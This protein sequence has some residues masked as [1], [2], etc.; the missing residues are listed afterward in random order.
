MF[1]LFLD[2]VEIP[3][4]FR[5]HA[6]CHYF[7]TT[8]T[9]RRQY[10]PI[11]I[12]YCDLYLDSAAHYFL[13]T[14]RFRRDASPHYFLTTSTFRHHFW[15]SI[16]S[17]YVDISSHISSRYGSNLNSGSHGRSTEQRQQRFALAAQLLLLDWICWGLWAC[18]LLR[19]GVGGMGASWT[20]MS[21]W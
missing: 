5:R 14:S 2:Y 7:L 13:T 18:G 16:F 3:S 6:A 10:F 20:S 4:R 19:F 9:F 21:P 8:S 17:D 15:A 1:C 12:Q 11:F